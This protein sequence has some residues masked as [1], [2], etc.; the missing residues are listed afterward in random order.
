MNQNTKLSLEL[1]SKLEDIV[2]LL[3]GGKSLSEIS[4][5]LGYGYSGLYNTVKKS[6]Y[7]YLLSTKNNGKSKTAKE[8]KLKRRK[9]TNLDAEN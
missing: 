1:K 6:E 2:K 4:I 5:E 7:S 9:L 3:K 8:E